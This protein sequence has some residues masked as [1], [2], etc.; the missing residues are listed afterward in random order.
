VKTLVFDFGNVIGF[1]D[2]WIVSKRLA[3]H[4]GISVDAIHANLW[5]S[6]LEDD[7][8]AGRISTA[9]F[10]H[11]VRDV[12]ELRCSIEELAAAYEDIFWP[13]P[14]VIALL[15]HL[16]PRYRLLLASNTNELHARKFLTQ[17]AESLK[18]FD[19]LVLSHQA[20]ARKPRPAFFEYC[21]RLAGC[22]PQECLFIDDLPANV[23]GAQ[24]CGWHGIVY[25]SIDDLR[26]Q[27]AEHGVQPVPEGHGY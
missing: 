12:C 26:R 4:A 25:R 9:D 22:A 23:A 2:H 16:K 27:L 10:L 21:Q 13:N 8:E 11:K 14:D 18:V 15:P 6:Q 19:A 17:F 24:A 20:G 3:P 1:F 7:Y 5:D